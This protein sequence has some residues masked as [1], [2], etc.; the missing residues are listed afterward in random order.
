MNT[1][2]KEKQKDFGVWHQTSERLNTF[3]NEF[4]SFIFISFFLGIS[5]NFLRNKDINFFLI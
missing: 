4:T 3:G 2:E 5:L 1:Y